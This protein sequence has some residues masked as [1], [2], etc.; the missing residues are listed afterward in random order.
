M[1]TTRAAFP[2]LVQHHIAT[3][4]IIFSFPIHPQQR[5]ANLPLS[6]NINFQLNKQASKQKSNNKKYDF[7]E[8]TGDTLCVC[9]VCVCVCVVCVFVCVCIYVS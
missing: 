3:T 5:N 1:K 4:H 9:T 6:L 8:E 7:L 2:S